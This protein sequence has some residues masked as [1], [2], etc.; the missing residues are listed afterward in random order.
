MTSVHSAS[1]ARAFMCSPR[2]AGADSQETLDDK[3]AR[4]RALGHSRRLM[5]AGRTPRIFFSKWLTLLSVGRLASIASGPPANMP[6]S[7]E[8]LL[9]VLSTVVAL[10][11]R[12]VR[13]RRS[14]EVCGLSGQRPGACAPPPGKGHE[15]PRLFIKTSPFAR[16][17]SGMT[18][19]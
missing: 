15:S 16:G 19:E 18:K 7:I 17:R 13:Y 3:G 14:P 11:L 12:V 8:I 6:K 9:A 1:G 5:F 4:A 2:R 10:V